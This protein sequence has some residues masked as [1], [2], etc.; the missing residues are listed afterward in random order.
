MKL[1]ILGV[2]GSGGQAILQEAL[3]R[4]HTVTAAARQTG[5]FHPVGDATVVAADALDAGIVDQIKGHDAVIVAVSGRKSG[6]DTFVK[7]ANNLLTAL[8][9]AGVSRLLWVGGAGS[10][11]VAPGVRLVDSPQFPAMYKDEALAQS[12]ALDVLR[13]SNTTV[14]WTYVSP[15]AMIGPGGRSGKYRTGGDQLLADANGVSTISWAD[16]A[17]ALVDT[18]EKN[19]HPK[20][21]IT[22]AY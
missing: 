1:F 11:E 21:R 15:P 9:A 16:F 14:N 17:V 22:V 10:L 5:Y 2:T 19:G 7:A 18:L 13:M 6:H 12:A 20:T 4:G 8:P 3:T